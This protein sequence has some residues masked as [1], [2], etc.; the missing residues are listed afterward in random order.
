[1]RMTK[2]DLS[3]CHF[4]RKISE[5][6]ELRF[7]RIASRRVLKNRRPYLTSLIIYRKSPPRLNGH[8]DWT[9]IGRACGIG[10]K[11]ASSTDFCFSTTR[12]V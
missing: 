5:F 12:S 11:A 7:D 8:I 4:Q 9:M 1:M 6:Y 3:S 10:A 2:R